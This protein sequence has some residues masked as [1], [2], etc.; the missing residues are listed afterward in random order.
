M[1]QPLKILVLSYSQSGQ[2]HEITDN[3]VNALHN[4]DIDRQTYS[5]KSPFPFPWT[6][7]E[8]FNTMPESVM[9]KPIELNEITYK[10]LVY[11][12]I[13][14]AYQ[15]WYLSPS[16]PTSSI[17][18]N[19]E[20]IKRVQNTP[21]ITLVGSR[22][23]WINSQES[24]KNRI[25]KAGGHIVGNIP[26]VDRTQN[27]ISAVTILHWALKGEK[28]KKWNIFPRPGIS[29]KDI[30]SA[31]KYGEILNKAIADKDFTNLQSKFLD[32]KLISIPTDILFI[33]EKAKRLFKIWVRLITRYGTTH[34]KR[35][36]LINLF[37]YYL[38]VALF[39]VAPIV[40]GLYLL[41]IVP[42]SYKAINKRKQIYLQ[43]TN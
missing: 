12:L 1:N 34:R 21:I 32:L 2:L 14:F 33:E 4:V 18:Q 28:T 42:F 25:K 6:S 35:Q 29:D 8:F 36:L 41:L 38:F 10:Y 26:F 37:K 22:N 7:K 40:F 19:E 20:F 13:I 16:I 27:Q 15:P 9:E 30:L 31:V 11:D 17:L 5:P 39:A 24:V 43:Q 3:F 23:M